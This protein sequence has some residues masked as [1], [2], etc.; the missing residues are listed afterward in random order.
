MRP[1]L[2]V[3]RVGALNV[4]LLLI[5]SIVGMSLVGGL[6]GAYYFLVLR[7]ASSIYEKAVE[8][9][10]AE[11]FRDARRNYQRALGKEARDLNYL[12]SL[13][14]V[15]LLTSP[16]STVEANEF[17]SAWLATLEWGAENHPDLPERS[18][19]FVRTVYADAMDVQSASLM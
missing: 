10:K 4:K 19:I 14:R 18:Q 3:H 8:F 12:T 5:L 7:S 6:G 13:Q 9:E 15:I 2:S 1:D 16:N 17:Y 11:K